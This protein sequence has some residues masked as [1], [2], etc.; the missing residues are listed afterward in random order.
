LHPVLTLIAASL[1]SMC[2]IAVSYSIGRS[3]GLYTLHHYGRF[4]RITP[5]G[6]EKTHACYV[7]FGTWLL[8]FGY[9]IPEVRHFTAIVA[10]TLRLRYSHFSL[11]AYAGALVWSS[12]FIGIGFLFGDEW[13]G[14][15]KQI[16]RHLITIAWMALFSACI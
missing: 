1:G 14:V 12:V 7:R 16:H 13:A 3:M 5:E 15:F 2:G 8:F 6:I 4:F 9:F 10:G 11:F